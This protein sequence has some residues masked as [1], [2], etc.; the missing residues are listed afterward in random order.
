[1]VSRDIKFDANIMGLFSLFEYVTRSKVKDCFESQGRMV[2]IVPEGEISKAIGSHGIN[3][4]KLEAKLNKKVKIAEFNSDV[5]MFVRNYIMPLRAQNIEQDGETIIIT[6]PDQKTRGL[7][8][9]RNG[10]NL[11]ELEDVLNRYFKIKEVRVV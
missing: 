11:R 7:M 2:F 5:L 6:G 9:G 10:Q 1:M 3:V 4:K 8:I